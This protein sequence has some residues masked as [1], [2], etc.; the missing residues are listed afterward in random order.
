[1]SIK[2]FMEGRYI[3]RA[4]V[5]VNGKKKEIRRV[6]VGTRAKAAVLEKELKATLKDVKKAAKLSAAHYTWKTAVDDY[7]IEAERRLSLTTLYNRQTALRAHTTCWDNRVIGDISR[8]EVIDLIEKLNCTLANKRMQLK[9]INQVFVNTLAMRKIPMNPASGLKLSHNKGV[10]R[11]ANSLSAMTRDEVQALLLFFKEFSPKWYSIFFITY[12][13]GLRSSE[14]VA[15]QFSDIDFKTGRV[16]VSKSWCKLRKDTVPPKNGT[17]RVIMVN[18]QTLAFLKELR[19]KSK[20]EHEWVLP[21]IGQWLKG[22]ATKV[23]QQ[24]QDQLGI[25]RTNYHSL[26]ASFITHLLLAGE[27]TIRVQAMVGHSD[28]K[29]TMRYIRLSG[30]DLSGATDALE[31]DLES[32]GKVI[33]FNSKSI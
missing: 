1:M 8:K 30:S 12:Q 22:G 27:S 20:S 4:S 25:K 5:R 14:A 28:L 13:L 32:R 31:L 2:E 18:S 17:S 6:F 23:I 15:L 26:R 3:V 9:Y 10:D 24:A 16:V 11:K 7:L 33:S 29:T 21:R 19:L